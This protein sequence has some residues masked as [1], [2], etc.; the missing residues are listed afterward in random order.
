[1]I[2]K[3]IKIINQ[4]KSLNDPVPDREIISQDTNIIDLVLDQEIIN[5]NIIHIDPVLD[6][7]IIDRKNTKKTL[8]IYCNIYYLRDSDI[9]DISS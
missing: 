1:M 6:L 5:Q 3:E 8:K 9:K 7:K 2:K 4:D